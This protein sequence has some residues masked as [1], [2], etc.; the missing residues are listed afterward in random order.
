MSTPESYDGSTPGPLLIG[1]NANGWTL[2]PMV[3]VGS[4]PGTPTELARDFLIARLH[5]PYPDSWEATDPEEYDADFEYIA[6]ALCFD[7]SRVFGVG[8][9]AGG[10]FLTRVI[11]EESPSENVVRPLRFRAIALVGAPLLWD[12]APWPEIPIPLVHSIDDNMAAPLLGKDGSVAL[13]GIKE[14]MQCAESSAA[15][16][17]SSCDEATTTCTDFDNCSAPLRY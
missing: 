14:R 10:R 7:E 8:H 2:T 11:R 13:A 12:D 9:A 6:G 17:S 4:S 16:G 5:R 1:L 15:A 3:T